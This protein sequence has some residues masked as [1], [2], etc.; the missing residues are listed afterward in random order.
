MRFLVGGIDVLDQLS[1]LRTATKAG[2]VCICTYHTNGL[3][4]SESNQGS[5]KL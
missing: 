1:H 4:A 2:Y 3:T 5:K